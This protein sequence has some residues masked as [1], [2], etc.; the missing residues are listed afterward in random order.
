MV[1][2]TFGISGIKP[3]KVPD[4]FKTTTKRKK[5]TLSLRD[6]Q[7][8]YHRAKGRCEACGKKID[9]SEMQVG[10]KKAYSKGGA[11]TLAN[12]V[13][14]CYRC[15]KLQG[16][17]SFAT[18]KKKLDGTYGKRTKRT[19]TKQTS[20]KKRKTAKRISKN[21]FEIKIPKFKF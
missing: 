7:I 19:R 3:L 4:P 9:F 14:L 1:R 6:K 16:T 20:K 15:N 2:N 11:T 8:L 12:S 10:H 5:R 13:C 17:D 18:L 21:P